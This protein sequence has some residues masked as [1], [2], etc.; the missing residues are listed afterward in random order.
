MNIFV[1]EHQE[2]L[3]QL[4]QAEVDFLLIGGYAVIYYGYRRTTG[5]LDL[6]L[7]P[8]NENKLKFLKALE[9]SDFDDETLAAVGEFDFEQ[10]LTF[11]IGEEPMKIDFLTKVSGVSYETADKNKVLGEIDGLEIPVVH[12]NDLVISKMSS[13]RLKDKLD[14]E[15]LQKIA[16]NKK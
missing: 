16:K 3:K 10:M 1:E 5:D 6:W 9:L 7:R 4:I 2:I 12:L 14:I 11:T 13:N 8:T 15:E